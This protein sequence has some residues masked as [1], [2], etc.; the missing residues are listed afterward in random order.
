[1]CD[2]IPGKT[3]EEDLE[4]NLGVPW[5][6]RILYQ[7]WTLPGG[8]PEESFWFYASKEAT[9]EV[10]LDSGIVRQ[11]RYLVLDNGVCL[12]DAVHMYGPPE[13]VQFIVFDYPDG[14]DLIAFIW[15]AQGLVM[16][17]YPG[18]TTPPPPK[19]AVFL[20]QFPDPEEEPSPFE[21]DLPIWYIW[22]FEPMELEEIVS[23]YYGDEG[24][25]PWPGMN[26]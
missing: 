13:R 19:L 7:G 5:W 24:L 1:V 21:A 12:G 25:F 18:A 8:V 4:A 9:L 6:T 16:E 11:V 3:T 17:M 22:Y 26:E 20:A 23:T 10:F 2:T 14:E 15:P